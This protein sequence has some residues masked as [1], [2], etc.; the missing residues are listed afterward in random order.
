MA[1]KPIVVTFFQEDVASE[2][3]GAVSEPIH[4][5][6]SINNIEG[7]RNNVDALDEKVVERSAVIL[8]G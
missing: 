8:Q 6:V 4:T 1:R 2:L 7:Y 5:F 3:K